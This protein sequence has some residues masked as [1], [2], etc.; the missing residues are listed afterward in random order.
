M[1]VRARVL[2]ARVRVWVEVRVRVR[3]ES[4]GEGEVSASR[5]L[6]MGARR[7]RLL[8]ERAAI[9]HGDSGLRISNGTRPH[10][11]SH[12]TPGM[13]ASI[14]FSWHGTSPCNMQ[15]TCVRGVRF[16]GLGGSGI[17]SIAC[18]RHPRYEHASVPHTT[19]LHACVTHT[20]STAILPTN[21]RIHAFSKA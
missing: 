18:H 11:F 15:A 5:A 17:S 21:L 7:R 16:H 2:R 8:I 19:S 12:H 6:H 3:G 13:R 4:G 9:D 10:S 20:P 14:V 1:R